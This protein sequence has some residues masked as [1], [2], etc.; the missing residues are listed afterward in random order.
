MKP[1]KF[2]QLAYQKHIS[3]L[4]GMEKIS[5]AAYSYV[6]SMMISRIVKLLKEEKLAKSDDLKRGW[7]G[8]VP[9][10]EADFAKMIDSVINKHMD[11]LRYILLG[12][13]AGES[14]KKAAQS[15]GLTDKI[16]PGV[17]H[18]AYMDSLDTGRQHYTDLLDK[19]APDI[20][21]SLVEDSLDTIMSKTSKFIDESLLRLKN[22]VIDA[23]ETEAAVINDKN[24]AHVYDGKE[25][26]IVDKM[27]GRSI[28]KAIKV[29]AEGYRTDWNRMVSVDMSLASAVG[30]HQIVSEVYGQDDGEVRVALVAI[31]DEKTCVICKEKSRHPGGEFKLHRMKDFKPAGYNYG[32]KKA[33][34]VLCIPPLHINC[35]CVLVYVPSGFKITTSGD[36][37]P[38]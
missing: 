27:S 20:P 32:K 35:R 28:A 16:I 30:T 17:I 25:H 9:K 1:I 2:M 36:V 29:A 10:I 26:D 15:I 37:L 18:A 22:R 33:E 38:G 24:I 11:A 6:V 23:V 5:D 4:E 14:A 12:S 19:P 31:R 7:T 13:A 21:S 8:K 34:W 3:T